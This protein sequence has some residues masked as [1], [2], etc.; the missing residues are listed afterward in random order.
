MAEPEKP[1][2]PENLPQKETGEYP[3]GSYR[4][5]ALRERQSLSRRV[6]LDPSSPSVRSILR[7]VVIVLF[8][9][10]IANWVQTL[11][12]SLAALAFLIVLSIFFAY[13]IDPLVR[14][15]RRPFKS[16]SIERFMP[17][18]IAIMIAYVIVFTVFGVAI[19]SIAP[20][21][22]DQAKEFGTNL[23]T[24]TTSIKDKIHDLNRRFDRLRIPDE[25]QA[26]VNT[27]ITDLGTYV[28]SMVGNFLLATATYLP[29]LILVPILAFF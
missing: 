3:T 29:W 11:I 9:L 28:T 20:R 26:D 2:Q 5:A 18:W 6:Y 17:R 12:S 7:V 22:V 8:F 19:A 14:A 15:I 23:P 27:R 16:R 21:V 13:L 10:F 25:V 4:K 1:T 24:Y